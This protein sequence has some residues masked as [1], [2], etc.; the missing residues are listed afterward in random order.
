[1]LRR[2]V[3]ELADT[4]AIVCHEVQLTA[5]ITHFKIAERLFPDVRATYA[6]LGWWIEKPDRIYDAARAVERL[7][8]R[9]KVDYAAVLEGLKRGQTSFL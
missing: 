5:R 8:W 3:W 1:M 7:G 9:P 6:K 2:G 4:A